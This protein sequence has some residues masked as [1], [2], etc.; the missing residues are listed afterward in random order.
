MK[1]RDY[2]DQLNA[3]MLAAY[4]R[5]SRIATSYLRVHVKYASKD[6]S[7]SLIKSLAR[8]SE[9]KVSLSEVLEHFGITESAIRNRAA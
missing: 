5:R 9:G 7:V 2:I 4:A 8:E 3:E 1:L 6:P